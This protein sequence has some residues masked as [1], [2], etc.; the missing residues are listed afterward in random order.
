M[1]RNERQYRITK[2]QADKFKRALD[3]SAAQS[4]GKH[5]LLAQ[6]TK[7]A[8][9]SQYDELREQLD[10]YEALTSGQRQALEVGSFDDLADVLIQARIATGMTQ[11]ALAERLG[12]KEQQVQR[13]EA[14]EYRSASLSRLTEVVK[15]LG[16]KVRV[17]V[18]QE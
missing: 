12:L 6:A 1:I 15:A 8:L 2:A 9:Q 17:S 11:K 16:V 10:E 5:P 3:E 13:Y 18:S 4:A 14:T 7:D